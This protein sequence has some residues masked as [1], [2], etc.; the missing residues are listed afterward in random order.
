MII[1]DN[2]TTVRADITIGNGWTWHVQPEIF[3]KNHPKTSADPSLKY[4]P[5]HLSY[6]M[7]HLI[8]PKLHLLHNL[9]TVLE[10]LLLAIKLIPSHLIHILNIP[11]INF[12]LLL[13]LLDPRPHLLH[14][15]LVLV[16]DVRLEQ[17]H[18]IPEESYLCEEALRVYAGL[19]ADV[20]K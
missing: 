20:L 19:L 14:Y 3:L 2:V 5:R 16:L 9:L 13:Q 6:F 17:L 18:L 1:A 10:D 12:D 8:N 4:F 15:I 7:I 11:P